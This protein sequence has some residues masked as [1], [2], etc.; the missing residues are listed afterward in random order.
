MYLITQGL[1]IIGSI[2]LI[3]DRSRNRHVVDYISISLAVVG[4]WIASIAV[5]YFSSALDSSRMYQISLIILAPF[6]VLG[7]IYLFK[8]L[9][10]ISRKKRAIK[11]DQTIVVIS[12]FLAV[13]LLFNTGLIYALCGEQSNIIVSSIPNN[14]IFSDPELLSAKFSITSNLNT[15]IYA[16]TYRWY[17]IS[18][19]DWGKA[20]LIPLNI[21]EINN[22]SLIYFG[23]YN[24]H[25][26]MILVQ[27]NEKANVV[28]SYV[29]A[30]QTESRVSTIY[31]NS[32]SKI[33][34]SNN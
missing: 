15:P 31:T 20:S 33:F 3:I 10:F 21:S 7:C 32:Y 8:I 24:I 28:S 13:F 16:D 2:G 9:R 34:Y 5:P 25:S 30:S 17:L 26:N 23:N 19:L 6:L 18:G 1:I 29:N 12:I 11:E 14:N 4:L 22:N 27:Y